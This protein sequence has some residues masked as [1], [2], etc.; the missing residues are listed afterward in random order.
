MSNEELNAILDRGDASACLEFFENA[1]EAE[2]KSVA[3]SALQRA[4]A[5]PWVHLADTRVFEIAVLASASLSQWK[6]RPWS[7]LSQDDVV[8]VLAARR[9]KWLDEWAQWICEDTSRHQF[10]WPAL[11]RLERMGLC[12][13]PQSDNYSRGMVAWLGHAGGGVYNAL[14]VDPV[15]LEDELWKIFQVG[16]PLYESGANGWFTALARL[17]EEGRI[18]RARLLDASLDALE[19]DFREDHSR[20]YIRL[21]AFLSPTLEERSERAERYLGLVESRNASTVAFALRALHEL[22]PKKRLHA[23]ALLEHLRPALLAR[24]KGI[25]LSAVQLLQKGDWGNGDSH[26]RVA[27]LAAEALANPDAQVEKKALDVIQRYA[28]PPGHDLKQV[29][30]DRLPNLAPSQRSRLEAWLATFQPERLAEHGSISEPELDDLLCRAAALDPE[31]TALAGVPAA[32]EAVSSGTGTLPALRFDG[33]EMPRLN[34]EAQLKPVDELDELI[35]LFAW[36][37]ENAE[38]ADEV[39]RALDGV[40]RLC[41]EQPSDFAARVSPLLARSNELATKDRIA[42]NLFERSL[43]D[44]VLAWVTGRMWCPPG[45]P[46]YF[47]CYRERINELIRQVGQPR[48]APLLATP[49]HRGGWIDPLIL[50]SRVRQLTAGSVSPGNADG[51]LALLRLAP[52]RRAA[53]LAEVAGV[54]GEFASAL[55]YALGSNGETIGPT[56]NWWVSAARARQPFMDDD[57]LEQCHPGLGPDAGLAASYAFR[58]GPHKL[59]SAW[60]QAPNLM[61]RYPPLPTAR[62]A[63]P[64]T[65][66]LH[67]LNRGWDEPLLRWAATVWPLARESLF[68]VGAEQVAGHTGVPTCARMNRVYLEP[69][70]D[71]DVPLKPMALHLLALALSSK[72]PDESGLATDVLIAAIND[73]RLDGGELGAVMHALEPSGLIKPLR[74]AKGLEALARTSHLHSQVVVATLQCLLQGDAFPYNRDRNAMLELLREQLIAYGDAVTCAATRSYLSQWQGGGQTG[75]LS[76]QLLEMQPD[77][78]SPARR[79]ATIQDLAGRIERVERWSRARKSCRAPWE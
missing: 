77:A 28:N 35:D 58:K 38:A 8:A 32:I 5:A 37:L 52:E 64:A 43:C 30:G 70:F 16:V 14:C 78:E 44:V 73:R 69:L 53:A 57:A 41:E 62:A 13:R 56:A 9:P 51:L 22:V 66:Q 27:L 19:A 33:T 23:D 18:P 76:R 67:R 40:A 45:F 36:V 54:A 71:P 60:M 2:R 10:H 1:T 48:A 55:R 12:K 74:W 42:L 72:Q 49:T 39:E 29:L 47:M 68:A 63:E 21:Y 20:G 75:K 50:A 11:R 6:R 65:V 46:G 34:P 25:V 31:L 26:A 61:E 79:A 17:A 7:Y 15:L 3:K 24:S 59:A 4:R